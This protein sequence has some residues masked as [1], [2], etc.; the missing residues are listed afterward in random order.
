MTR[1]LVVTSVHPPDDP[2]IRHKTAVSLAKDFDVRYATKRPGPTDR[3]GLD[4]RP[5]SG[6]RP[7]RAAAALR[8]MLRPDVDIVSVHDPELLPAALLVERLR[9]IPVVFD[10]HEH[11]LSRA[12]TS[13]AVPEPLVGATSRTVRRLLDAA[14]RRLVITLAEEGYASMFHRPHPVLPNYPV[15]GSLP[16]PR[17][18]ADDAPVVYVGDVTAARGVHVLLRAAAVTGQRVVLIGRCAPSL[19]EEVQQA[20]TRLNV[21]AEL[22]GWRDHPTA[23]AIAAGAAVAVS[24]LLN[25]PNYRNSLPTKVLEY[26]GM[27]LPVVA[28]ALPGTVAVLGDA[29]GARLVPP[30]DPDALAEGLAWAATPAVR[31]LA[32]EDAPRIRAAYRWPDGRLRDTFE[33]LVTRE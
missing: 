24:P 33:A 29:P 17:P 28:S 15:A 10:V 30:A 8:E 11:L 25:L 20:A 23:L 9:G 12:E 7:A 31:R 5:L 3:T 4:W 32:A 1:V 21:R 16:D 22:L 18:A 13:E 27:G 26:A 6:P 19:R 2:R 14:E